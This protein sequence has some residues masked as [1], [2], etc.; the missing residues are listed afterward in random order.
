[1]LKQILKT[2]R[3]KW[4]LA[5]LIIAVL[6]AIVLLSDGQT[7]SLPAALILVAISVL[8]SVSAAKG[9]K[10]K[11]AEPAPRTI[12][13]NGVKLTVSTK[14]SERD[15]EMFL[16]EGE[17]ISLLDLGEGENPSGGY[18][19]WSAYKVTGTG[20]SGKRKSKQY[21]AKTEAK[22]LALAQKDGLLEPYEIHAVPHDSPTE[23]QINYLHSWNT[24]VPDGATR[25]D[26]S[27][28]LSRLEG[29]YDVV[30]EKQVAGREEQ[31]IRP[32]PG[33]SPEF[34]KYANEMG[35]HFS[36]FVGADSLFNAV[37]NSLDERD[38]VAFFAYCALCSYHR[39]D[40]G[41]LLTS[42]YKEKLYEFA[43]MA[44]QDAALLTSVAQ[45][46]PSDYHSPH[47]GT[48]A[49]KAV[50]EFFGLK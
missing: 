38:K 29:S 28:I 20:E 14:T 10:K 43:D 33:P 31:Y 22:A 6:G 8:L 19:N 36:R 4:A 21:H 9:N 50:A 2:K 18:V 45:R 1:M 5:L 48:K 40:I 44:L 34:A 26:V 24:M 16:A 12:E 46:E 3:G 39:F 30:C 37:V 49:Y 35:I 7:K 32:L 27:A 47:K 13:A 15:V 17:M 41:N 11:P 23:K 25:Y 42:Q